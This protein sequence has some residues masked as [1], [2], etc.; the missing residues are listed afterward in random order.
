MVHHYFKK[1]TTGLLIITKT[2]YTVKRLCSI[3]LTPLRVELFN[4]E[5]VA[6]AGKLAFL[7]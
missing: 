5:L 7:R 2:V 1:G 3:Y 4:R 6:K